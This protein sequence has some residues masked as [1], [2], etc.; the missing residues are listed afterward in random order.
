[1][2]NEMNIEEIGDHD[3]AR[4]GLGDGSENIWDITDRMETYKIS[5]II[6]SLVHQLSVFSFPLK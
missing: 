6:V 5:I 4:L 1:M 2:P 3:N